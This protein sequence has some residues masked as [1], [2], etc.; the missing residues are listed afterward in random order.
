MMRK[1]NENEDTFLD[2]K[3]FVT[4]VIAICFLI[5]GSIIIQNVFLNIN[6]KDN[7][8]SKKS[9]EFIKINDSLSYDKSTKIVFY[10]FE[11]GFGDASTG[12]LSEYRNKNGKTCKYVNG[13]IVETKEQ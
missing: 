12:Y 2:F 3:I 9:A 8:D 1:N 10:K 5:L 4:A 13:K 11:E 7:S 6:Y